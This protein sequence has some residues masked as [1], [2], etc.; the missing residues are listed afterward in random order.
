MIEAQKLPMCSRFCSRGREPV[1]REPDVVLLMTASGSLARRQ[2]FADISAKYYKTANTYRVA[3]QSY[4]WCRFRFNISSTEHW[5]S[6]RRIRLLLWLD[7]TTISNCMA[8]VNMHFKVRKFHG[9]LGH[10]GS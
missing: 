7:V 8:L 9:S 6:Q 3:L 4:H 2:I 5:P 10:K 1:A